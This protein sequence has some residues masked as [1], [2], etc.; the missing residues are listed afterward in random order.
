MS[1]RGRW[2]LTGAVV[3]AIGV[4]ASAVLLTFLAVVAIAPL[5]PAGEQ[6][7]ELG[8]AYSVFSFQSFLHESGMHGVYAGTSA[9]S[10][11]RTL[12]QIFNELSRVADEGIPSDEIE[13]GKG[14]LKGQLTLSLESPASRM[15][16]VASAVLYDE[17][18]LTLDESLAKIDAVTPAQVAEATGLL[19]G[20]K[21]PMA[22]YFSQ[23][24]RW[25][26][27][28]NEV[29]GTTSGKYTGSITYLGTPDNAAADMTLMATMAATGVSPEIAGTTFILET[30]DGGAT[31]S[32]R[33]GGPKPISD[34]YLPTSCK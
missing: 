25:P 14:Q 4:S 1:D 10:A 32:C 31:W 9:A 8:L 22:E 17:P 15:F 20:A 23:S 13:A 7:E 21:S 26:A 18:F 30:T 16:R 5:C 34:S 6:R 11:S 33:R 24:K 2:Q 29:L 12:E 3:Y 28:P 19:W 27:T